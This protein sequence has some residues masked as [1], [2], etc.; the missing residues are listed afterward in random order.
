MSATRSGCS[1][2]R[3]PC[4][5]RYCGI[6]LCRVTRLQRPILPPA[7]DD[8]ADCVRVISMSGFHFMSLDYGQMFACVEKMKPVQCALYSD[9]K[10]RAIHEQLS[11]FVSGGGHAMVSFNLSTR[12]TGFFFYETSYVFLPYEAIP[13]P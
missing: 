8:T 9:L 5:V 11:K 4:W 12:S 2:G 7:H 3:S 13:L 10:I 1:V 6:A